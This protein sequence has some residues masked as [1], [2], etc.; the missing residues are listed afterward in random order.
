MPRNIP[1]QAANQ[2]GFT[3][4]ELMIIIAIVG[5]LSAIAVVSYQTYIRKA[6]L[7]TIYQEINQFRILYQVLMD[8]NSAVT[9]FSLDNLNIPTQ[10]KY[11]QFS[12][13]AP[14]NTGQATNALQCRV[15]NLNY[16]TS[17]YISLDRSVDGKWQC[18][19]SAGIPR[20]YLPQ[21]CR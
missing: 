2:R 3:L 14:D 8:A 4:I 1:L 17:Q 18:H 16:L 9:V 21:A 7:I 19:A 5:V 11:C 20:A 10:T 13:N 12:V 6:H 15:Q